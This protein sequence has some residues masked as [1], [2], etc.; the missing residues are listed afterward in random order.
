M[1]KGIAILS[2]A[3]M[4]T[5]FCAAAVWAEGGAPEPGNKTVS[6][7]FT[8]DMHSHMD[9]EKIVR[10]GNTQERGGFARVRTAV[11]QIKTAYPDSLL[12]DGGD[13]SMGTPYQSIFS[14]EASEL[15][16]MGTLQFDA[17][18]FGNHEFDYRA[19]G[20]A[21]MLNSAVQSGD[22]LPALL[23]ANVD[24]KRTLADKG[25]KKAA[26]KL[27]E[28]C[29]AYGVKPYEV[30]EKGGMRIAVFG[31]LG[32]EADEFAPESGLYFKDPVES[33]KSIV[34]EIK[35]KEN[36]DM[37]VC[38]S[39][40]GTSEDP[41]KS[42]DE[43]LAKEVPDIDVIISGHSHTELPEPIMVGSTAVVS[44]GS[45]T[46]KLGHLVMEKG[47]DGGF[48][49]KNYQLIPLDSGVEE[50]A[51]VLSRLK[52]FEKL[53]DEAYFSEFGYGMKDVLAENDKAFT[54]IEQ[55]SI[56]QGE[57]PLGNL[58]A[59]SYIYGVRR[60]EGKDSR[61]ID[62]AVVPA[63]VVRAS[64]G[65]GPVTVADAF[66]VLS[67]G[68]G[69]DGTT[70]YPLVSAY[71]TGKELRAVAEVDASV[72]DMMP[73]ARLYSSGLAYN[74]NPRRLILNRAVDI[75]L[76]LGNGSY[77]E[78][79]DD[80]LYRVATDLYSCQMLGSVKEQSFGLLSIE[81]KDKEGKPIEN[82]EDHIIYSGGRELKAWY[83]LASYLES[84][85]DGKIPA[86]YGQLQGRK[87]EVDSLNPVQLL[88]QPNKIMFMA[89]GAVLLLAAV[90]T[91]VSI[92]ILRRRRRK[93]AK[94]PQQ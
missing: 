30:F 2:A 63:G 43:I 37:I 94:G 55:F 49:L 56:V 48:H 54:D 45:Y 86:D 53:A 31:I 47:E 72:S 26:S 42:E 16:M 34:G 84:F 87:A 83:A 24:W 44:C 10:D 89:L 28:A 74:Y 33:S 68:Y 41:D 57:D 58:I 90:I 65:E 59:D 18:T 46:Y 11:N 70:G 61:P 51:G 17:T 22:P 67:L 81:P 35:E 20:L 93:A 62:V 25:K 52:D 36:A 92:M 80:R 29:G 5:L 4:T 3:L 7:I 12:L 14:A 91:A 19:E 38:L 82:F 64:L 77:E 85:E 75:C 1:K 32:R 6:I 13:F 27:K 66:N 69:K 15:R 76:D 8:H 60:A 79:K 23:S 50:D 21:D 40:S 39:H 73:V 88:K 71:L 9:G 78:L